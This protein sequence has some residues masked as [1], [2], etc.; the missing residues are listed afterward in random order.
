MSKAFYLVVLGITLVLFSVSPGTTGAVEAI[1]QERL[2]IKRSRHTSR[3]MGDKTSA[4][5]D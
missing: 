1:F 4:E 5:A 3:T 2:P